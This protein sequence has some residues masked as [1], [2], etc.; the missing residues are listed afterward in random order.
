MN[1]S[2]SQ[3]LVID[4][5]TIRSTATYDDLSERMQKQWDKKA[6]NLRN[7]EEITPD[8]MYHERAGIYAE[9]GQVI[10]IAVGFYVY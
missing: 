8:E 3:I 10:V 1:P 4:I 2:P 5:E 7:V 9:F 6:F